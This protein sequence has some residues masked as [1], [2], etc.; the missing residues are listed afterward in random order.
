MISYLETRLLQSPR[1]FNNVCHCMIAMDSFVHII[2]EGLDTYLDSGDAHREHVIHVVFLRPVWP[3]FDR[4]SDISH[5]ST[6]RDMLSLIKGFRLLIIESVY[7]SLHKFF[8]IRARHERKGA[9][10]QDQFHL[11]DKVAHVP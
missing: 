2:V 4:D 1:G 7:A 3:S 5:L 11:V 8:L 10:N 6:L 9:S